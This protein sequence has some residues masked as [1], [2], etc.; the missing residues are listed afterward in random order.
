[1]RYQFT[2]TEKRYDGKLVYRT[3]FYP[4]IPE[5]EDDIYITIS[6][7][8]YLDSLSKKYYGDES[9][10]WVIA[11]ANNISDGKLSV[12]AEKQLRIPGNLSLIMQNLK[13]VNS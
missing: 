1:M 2:P 7:D 11:V 9:Y 13:Q 10:W 12:K 6:E 5:S 4:T 8:N 3:T